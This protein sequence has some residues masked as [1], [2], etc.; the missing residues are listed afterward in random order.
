MDRICH[1]CVK[2]PHCRPWRFA[3]GEWNM[4]TCSNCLRWRYLS[5]QVKTMF[6]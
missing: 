3:S 1:D 4:G 5:F 6:G 2:L